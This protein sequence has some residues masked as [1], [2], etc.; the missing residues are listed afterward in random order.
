MI[1]LTHRDEL[2]QRR[3][4]R[5][6]VAQLVHE[7][8]VRHQPSYRAVAGSVDVLRYNEDLF[9]GCVADPADA[10]RAFCLIV[11]IEPQPPRLRVDGSREPN[12]QFRIPGGYR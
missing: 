6:Q 11:N 9:R 7:Y 10:R 3:A 8:V 1:G 12:S 5:R 4:E 2:Q